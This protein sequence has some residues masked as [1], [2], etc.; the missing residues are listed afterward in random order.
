MTAEAKRSPHFGTLAYRRS[1]F[2]HG[3]VR[4]ADTSLGE[5]FCFAERALDAGFR[6]MTVDN[7]DGTFIYLRHANTWQLE[8][9]LK[10]AIMQKLAPVDEPKWISNEDRAFMVL[11]RN[12]MTQSRL[13]KRVSA[14]PK[15]LHLCVTRPV[16]VCG[17]TRTK[18]YHR[19]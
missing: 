9:G 16:C 18:R 3:G 13:T 10:E 6:H 4:Y 7:T 2:T 14:P 15:N 1:V 12:T 17:L 19:C 8:G 11:V 5:D